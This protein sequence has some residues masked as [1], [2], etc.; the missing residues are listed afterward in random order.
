M[1]EK[2]AL[3]LLTDARDVISW[4]AERAD[5]ECNCEPTYESD[6]NAYNHKDACPS[7]VE[8]GVEATLTNLE[9]AIESLGRN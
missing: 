3:R 5:F 6:T 7:I 9:A 8:L 4:L 1:S 2:I